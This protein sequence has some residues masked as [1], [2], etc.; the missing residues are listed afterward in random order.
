MATAYCASGTM[1]L[2]VNPE[3]VDI[4]NCWLHSVYLRERLG[5]TLAS[6]TPQSALAPLVGRGHREGGIGDH[7]RWIPPTPTPPYKGEGDRVAIAAPS[8]GLERRVM[9]ELLLELFSEEIPARMQARAAEDLQRLVVEG[10]E[11]AGPR[12]RRGDGLRDA[13]P[14]DA[15]HR[16]RAGRSPAVSEERKGPRVGAPEQAIA[17]FL[18]SAGLDP[19]TTPKSSTTTRRATTTSPRSRSPAA[20][21]RI[22]A[23]VVAA[24]PR[25][26]PWPKSMRWGS[27][28]ATRG[29][30]RCT[31]SLPAR[32]QGRAVRHAAGV[33]ASNTT[34][35]HRF[36]GNEPFEVKSFERLR[37]QAEGAQG[38]C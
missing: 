29:C 37:N 13:A 21:Q 25:Q 35:G 20:P 36:H 2:R 6:H 32:R 24:V 19:S 34:R 9:S 27:R 30:G 31:A 3:G 14:A 38:A 8:R 7:W 5:E 22:M 15:G 28:P 1:K 16:G 10:A 18:K 4:G 11:G 17:G 33:E 23:E 12:G 26:V